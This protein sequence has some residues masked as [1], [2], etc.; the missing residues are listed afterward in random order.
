MSAGLSRSRRQVFSHQA[1][2]AR[3]PL[4]S[5][6]VTG[7]THTASLNRC[8]TSEADEL[9]TQCASNGRE[10]GDCAIGLRSQS[11]QSLSSVHDGCI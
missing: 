2:N 7:G 6:T 4:V 9:H 5:G 3:S 11:E 10:H 1:A 8:F